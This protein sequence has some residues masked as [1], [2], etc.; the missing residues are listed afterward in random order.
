MATT[1]KV[2]MKQGWRGDEVDRDGITHELSHGQADTIVELVAAIRR[3]GLT[4]AEVRAADFRH[5]LLDESL[6]R[7][8]A[9]L[10]HGKGLLFLR[11]FPIDRLS[12]D[13]LRIVFWGV[14]TYFGRALSQSA[15]GVLLGDVR[16]KTQAQGTT[17]G[18]ISDRELAFH[19]DL[20]ETVSLFCVRAARRGGGNRFVSSLKLREVMEAERP[21]LVAALIRGFKVW[22][23]DEQ[24]EEDDA[25]TPYD[26]PFFSEKGGVRSSWFSREVAEGSAAMSGIPLTAEQKAAI[27]LVEEIADRPGMALDVVLA[28]G[29]AVFI[30][31]FEIYHARTPFDDWEEPEKKRLLFRLWLQGDPPRPID[32][33]MLAYHNRSGLQGIDPQ[34]GK[35]R[36]QGYTQ[37]GKSGNP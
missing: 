23:M 12:E 28:P 31:N 29:E 32:P 1:V 3:R 17:R 16:V 2:P 35:R 11:S 24:S 25:F 9:E 19:A 5:A 10:Q 37:W 6:G 7:L 26:V 36:Q 15:S 27:D 4:F 18:Y 30:N 33:A 34:P 8:A 13:D 20:A 14:G 21:D 22:R